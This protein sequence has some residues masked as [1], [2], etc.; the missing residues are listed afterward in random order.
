MAAA[1]HAAARQQ[2]DL[3]EHTEAVA[4]DVQQGHATAVLTSQGTLA[5]GLVVNCCGAWAA[6]PG[7]LH[8]PVRPVKGQMLTVAAPEGLELTH[9][10]RSRD[11]Y[12]VPRGAGRILIGS[13]VEE[14]GFDKSVDPEAIRRLQRLAAHFIPGLDNA[15]VIDSWAGLRPGTPDGLPIL[16]ETAIG[17]YYV[18]TGHFRNGILLAPVTAHVMSRLVCGITPDFDPSA[19][20][21]KRFERD[22]QAA[23]IF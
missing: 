1:L 21:L 22:R 12:L 8:I 6:E 10:I 7:P 11:V 2:I 16:G 20:S 23:N 4:I 3:R 15:A 17:N 18:S 19:F 14:A 13:T 9:V 5:A